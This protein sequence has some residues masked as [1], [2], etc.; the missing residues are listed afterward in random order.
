MFFVLVFWVWVVLVSPVQ[1]SHKNVFFGFVVFWFG[2]FGILT[3]AFLTFSGFWK[4]VNVDLGG[5]GGVSIYIYIYV[6]P[7]KSICSTSEIMLYS[8]VHERVHV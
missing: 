3:L 1:E 4:P 2:L 6:V 8:K 5:G 7:R